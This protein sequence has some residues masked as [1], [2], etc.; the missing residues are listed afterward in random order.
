MGKIDKG[1]SNADPVTA[2]MHT[3]TNE[4]S[5]K[6]KPGFSGEDMHKAPQRSE[7]WSVSQG[8][9]KRTAGGCPACGYTQSDIMDECP[10]CGIVLARL[11]HRQRLSGEQKSIRTNW[12]EQT[13]HGK[14]KTWVAIAATVFL[15]LILGIAL[16]KW[17][18]G[19]RPPEEK[20]A[21]GQP[22]G[23]TTLKKFTYDKLQQEVVDVS[24]KEPVLIEFY[25][26]H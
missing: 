18:T 4:F 17:T 10:S 6:R 25:A 23:A 9:G 19:Q 3:E 16:I 11:G 26:S 13:H 24:R 14:G 15:C 5:L 12:E 1:P 20:V 8:G 2:G 21:Q 22:Q 7:S